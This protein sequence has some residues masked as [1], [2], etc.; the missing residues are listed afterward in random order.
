MSL[1]DSTIDNPQSEVY[2]YEL[3]SNTPGVCVESGGGKLSWSP[4]RMTSNCVK[5]AS[6]TDSSSDEEFMPSKCL[7]VSFERRFGVPARI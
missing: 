3:D 5:A 6:D 2:C 1:N 7:S 4:I